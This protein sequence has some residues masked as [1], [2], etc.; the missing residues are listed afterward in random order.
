MFKSISI[1]KYKSY[2]S[3]TPTVIEID[4]S[5][6]ATFIYGSNGAGK[7]AIGEVE[8]VWQRASLPETWVSRKKEPQLADV[9]CE[10]ES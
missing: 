2:H 7:S 6:Q 10:A 9:G 3:T 5:K 8:R 1:S 4:T